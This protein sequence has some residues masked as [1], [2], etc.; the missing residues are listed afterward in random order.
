[1]SAGKKTF[2]A[3]E[4]GAVT[5]DW[6]VLTTAVVGIGVAAVFTLMTANQGL[7]DNIG[8]AMSSATLTELDFATR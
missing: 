8:S 1:M 5:V 6:V 7:G 4:D 2:L 3:D